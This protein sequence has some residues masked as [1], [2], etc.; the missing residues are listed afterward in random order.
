MV[1]TLFFFTHLHIIPHNDSENMFLG[2][3]SKFIE[4]EMQKYLI[5][6]SIHTPESIHVRLLFGSVYNCESFWVSL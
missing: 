5:Y 2:I 3:S 4:N 6:I 1:W